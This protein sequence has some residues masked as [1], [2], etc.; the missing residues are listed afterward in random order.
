MGNPLPTDQGQGIEQ[1]AGGEVPIEPSI[2]AAPVEI[3]EPK[4]GKI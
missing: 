1:G 3:P 4:G 2:N